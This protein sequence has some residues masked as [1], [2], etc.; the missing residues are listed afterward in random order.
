MP[1]LTKSQNIFLWVANSPLV[2]G[3]N[4]GAHEN[5]LKHLGNAIQATYRRIKPGWQ[6]GHTKWEEVD[7]NWR[8][9]Q[10]NFDPKTPADVTKG[11]EKVNP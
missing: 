10:H 3:H 9:I 2:F 6:G 8:K 11:A 7:Q 4:A 1:M 5:A